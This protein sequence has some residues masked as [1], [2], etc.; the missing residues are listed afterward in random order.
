MT[1]RDELSIPFQGIGEAV[2]SLLAGSAI[3]LRAAGRAICWCLRP[4]AAFITSG[5]TFGD[6]LENA[7]ILVLPSIV[8]LGFAAGAVYFVRPYAGIIGGT[9]AVAW[10]ITAWAL[11]PE[12]APA[13]DED[14]EDK[15]EEDDASENDQENQPAGE[16]PNHPP[17]QSIGDRILIATITAVAEAHNQGFKGIHLAE[18]LTYLHTAGICPTDVKVGHLRTFLET[19]NIPIAEQLNIRR[20]GNT[21]GVR[22]DALTQALGRPPRD[23]LKGLEQHLSQGPPGTPRQGPAEAP[24]RPLPAPSAEAS[25]EPTPTPHTQPLPHPSGRRLWAVPDPSPEKTA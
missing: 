20:K 21:Y 6:R 23:A 14:Q 17:G 1:L 15:A 7:G 18:L 4:A 5:K 13:A 22:H 8:G 25:P 19:A 16:Y 10:V 3:I 9:A 12:P 24:T 2:S 11:S